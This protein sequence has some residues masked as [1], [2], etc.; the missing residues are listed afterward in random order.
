M[1]DIKVNL[2]ILFLG[3]YAPPDICKP[4][5]VDIPDKVYAVYHHRIYKFLYNNFQN[6]ISTNDP[7]IMFDDSL[8]SKID[9]IF[10]LYN[11]MPFNNSEIFISSVAE[12]HKI[13]YLGATPNIRALAEDKHLAKMMAKSCGINT[14]EWIVY[15]VK[16]KIYPPE[17]EGP[18]FVKPRFGAASKFIDE[19]SICIDW[20]KALRRIKY[21]HSKQLDVI[22]EK[23]IDGI[24]YTSPVLNNFGNPLFLPCIKELSILQGNVVTYEQ[25]RKIIGGL[26]RSINED[27]Y[28][29]KK[30]HDNS[31]IMFKL[32]QPLDYTR[33]DYIVDSNT[34]EIFFLEF[35]VCCNLGEHSTISQSAESVGISYENLLLNITYSSLFRG[36]LIQNTFGKQF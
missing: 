1:E 13:P 33:F 7:K 24:Y 4:L 5:P 30:L 6:V 21:L 19:K 9:Y 14:P 27:L 22:L 18:Y 17:F 8:S 23:Q 35:N 10:S 3:H 20:E 12:Y 29:E 15:N 11:R 32:I 2:N 26:T 25:K 36:G 34:N 28:I 31:K 16:N